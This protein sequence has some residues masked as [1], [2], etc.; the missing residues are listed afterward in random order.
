V[1]PR[2]HLLRPQ[3]LGGLA[4]LGVVEVEVARRLTVAII[5]SGDEVVAPDEQPK[6]GQIRDVNSSTL[7]ALVERAGHFPIPL[8]IVPDTYDELAATARRASELADVVIL[9]A[10]SS[11]S[12]RDMTAEVI[13]ELGSPGILVHGVALRPGKPTILAVA[14]GTPVFGLPGNP[15]SC[16]VTFDLFVGPTLA[17]LSGAAQPPRHT[18]RARLS[19]NIPSATGREDYVQV[20]L[21]L[22]DDDL[23]AV[24]V[25]GK[26]NIIYTLVRSD[27]MVR[28]ELDA[29]GLTAGDT[30]PVVLF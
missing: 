3:D 18:V 9:S 2:G 16:M 25:F 1:L 28:V 21:E 14:D 23:W 8:G 11:V 24:P 17:E 26:S 5:S 13:G 27:G 12:T 29:G 7:A 20:R 15:V 19:H 30:V 6:P 22:R 10:G 4:A